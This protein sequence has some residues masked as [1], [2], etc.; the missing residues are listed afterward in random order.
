M[1]KT[2]LTLALLGACTLFC[3]QSQAAELIVGGMIDTGVRLYHTRDGVNGGQ[4]NVE[5]ADGMRDANRVIFIGSE[6]LSDRTDL[7]F[8]LEASYAS[9]SGAMKTSGSLFDRGAYLW[10]KNDSYGQLSAGRIG[11]MRSGGT[12]LTFDITG[13]RINPFGT[14]WG[15]IGSPM[16][17]LPFYGFP[18]S[19]MIQYDTPKFG[20]LQAHF[21]YSFAVSN[22]GDVTEGTSYADRYSAAALTYDSEKLNLVAMVDLMN[23][24]SKTAPQD[25]ALGVLVGGN[26]HFDAVT[27][28]SSAAWFR[29]SDWIPSL[30]GFSDYSLFE[31]LDRINGWSATVG[32]RI[33]AWGGSVNIYGLYMDADYDDNV[34]TE[35][36]AQI[37]KD[38]KRMAAAVGY[39]Y[40]LSKRTS[41]YGAA[42]VYKDKIEL[43][44]ANG[45]EFKN[46]SSAQV[47]LG[48]HHTF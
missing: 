4:T 47:I 7:G 1:T 37:G 15:D 27:L 32:A 5:M 30:P 11:V 9:D 20:G 2:K 38:L 25:D 16:L 42:A 39:E 13:Q 22:D 36:A 46:P 29:D 18:V 40:P 8:W 34:T 43:T 41:V 21:Q 31:G 12:P 23:E 44:A 17:S 14:G 45:H 6:K 10:L 3:A 35:R 28:Y 33:P 19:N 26:L 48:L 24:N